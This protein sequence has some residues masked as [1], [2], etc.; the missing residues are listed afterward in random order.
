MQDLNIT[1]EEPDWFRR[2][3]LDTVAE[4][5][6]ESLNGLKKEYDELK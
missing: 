4:V 6:D 2:D 5:K 1:G 3:V